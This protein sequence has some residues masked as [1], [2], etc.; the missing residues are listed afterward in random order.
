M[1][2]YWGI[3][4]QRFFL[5]EKSSCETK[6]IKMYENMNILVECMSVVYNVCVVMLYYYGSCVNAH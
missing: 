3:R 1:W 2:I 6:F 5:L 4:V